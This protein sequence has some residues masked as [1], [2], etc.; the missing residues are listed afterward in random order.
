MS[1]SNNNNTNV[2]AGGII[3]VVVVIGFLL[4]AIEK[5]MIQVSLTADAVGMAAQSFTTMALKI[6]LVLGLVAAGLACGYA[7]ICFTYK[8]YKLVK[9]ATDLQADVDRKL[10][11][12]SNQVNSSLKDFRI[13][14]RFDLN[15]MSRKLSE[16]LDKPTIA[17]EVPLETA[18]VATSESLEALAVPN[19]QNP[20]PEVMSPQ[21]VSNPF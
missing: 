20:E 10:T 12:F 13:E 15:Q 4:K 14:T 9:R 1:D 16:A 7:A 2:F 3:L 21:N 5:I 11:D 8:Y 18:V 17:P 19:E 6:A